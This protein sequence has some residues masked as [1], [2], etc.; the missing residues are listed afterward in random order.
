MLSRALFGASGYEGYIRIISLLAESTI[1]SS[2]VFAYYRGNGKFVQA[3]ILIAFSQGIVPLAALFFIGSVKPAL[4]VTA[5]GTFLVALF[6]SVPAVK[7]ALTC[8]KGIKLIPSLKELLRYGLARVPGDI[9]MAA[10]LALPVFLTANLF[11]IKQAGFVAFGVSMV[12]MVRAV[13]QPV[14]L[15]TLPKL[16]SILSEGR[17][18]EARTILQK[19]I[20]YTAIISFAVT[21]ALFLSAKYVVHYWLGP[22]FDE[23]T[24][25]VRL[26]MLAAVPNALF[27]ALRSSVDAANVKAVNAVNIYKALFVSA[28]AYLMVKAGHFPLTGIP[29]SFIIGM[30]V[31]PF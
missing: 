2:L 28:L 29:L 10:I 24:G 12:S 8:P 13:F 27:V 5:A 17:N 1:C 7:L 16:S 20:K 30:A 4:E 26:A 31:P 18:D 11:G 9:S 21:I 22:Q 15:I 19:T 3:N 6:F 23:A 14:G 25:I